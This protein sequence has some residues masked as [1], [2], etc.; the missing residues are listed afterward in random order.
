MTFEIGDLVSDQKG[1]FKVILE[2]TN[3]AYK[4]MHLCDTLP[5][6]TTSGN[7][8]WKK[9]NIS[10]QPRKIFDKYHFIYQPK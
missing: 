1:E 3:D 7:I 8:S 6:V 4:F 2:I 10:T 9:G 5:I